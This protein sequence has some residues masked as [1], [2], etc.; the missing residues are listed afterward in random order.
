MQGLYEPG[1]TIDPL[2]APVAFQLGA[3]ESSYVDANGNTIV[4]TLDQAGQIVSAMDEVGALP[5]VVRNEENLV[6][7][8]TVPEVM[9][10]PLPTMRMGMS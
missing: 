2:D 9:L 1:E 8:R 7:S 4:Y 5:T 3:V 6:T 10:P